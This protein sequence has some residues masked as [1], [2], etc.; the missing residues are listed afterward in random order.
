MWPQQKEW[1]VCP[2]F[3]RHY[4]SCCAI[5][6]NFS[7]V[8][9]SSG[10]FWQWVCGLAG[11]AALALWV[12]LACVQPAGQS[13]VFFTCPPRGPRM[14][15]S[16][17]LVWWSRA[18]GWQLLEGR[19]ETLTAAEERGL[20]L[21]QHT[22]GPLA[23]VSTWLSPGSVSGRVGA[24]QC[25]LNSNFIYHGESSFFFWSRNSLCKNSLPVSWRFWMLPPQPSGPDHFF[26]GPLWMDPIFQWF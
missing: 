22:L 6:R 25:L 5:N 9:V 17:H 16:T 18:G 12:G 11:V 24:R 10:K 15:R 26:A 2:S 23:K 1:G 20:A 7:G 19:A 8:V 3:L 4:N 14:R 13:H 21:T